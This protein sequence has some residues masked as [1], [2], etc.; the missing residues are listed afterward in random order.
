M[1]AVDD[2]HSNHHIVPRGDLLYL[3]NYIHDDNRFI[4]IIRRK[5]E[6]EHQYAKWS[7]QDFDPEG[8]FEELRRV[9]AKRYGMF[10]DLLKALCPKGYDYFGKVQHIMTSNAFA[11]T[12]WNLFKGWELSHRTDDPVII[13]A[14]E[15]SLN[16]SERTRPHGFN[17]RL[18]YYLKDP[19]IGLYTQIQQ[20]K[21]TSQKPTSDDSKILNEIYSTLQS[22]LTLWKSFNPSQ[23]KI[24]GF[25]PEE[26][27]VMGE[28]SGHKLYR[29][30]PS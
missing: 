19:S 22:I 5:I 23:H 28:R 4:E 29:V 6:L 2:N 7:R 24:H 27:D 11:W 1:Y 9:E 26:W 8:R 25:N 30:K 10:Q 3:W 21:E 16:R 14:R 18:W 13:S 15:G 17:P 12:G 20:L